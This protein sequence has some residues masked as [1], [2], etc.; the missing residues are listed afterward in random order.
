MSNFTP[1]YQQLEL[2]LLRAWVNSLKKIHDY[3]QDKLLIVY[4]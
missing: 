1:R 3:Q 2:V 4:M